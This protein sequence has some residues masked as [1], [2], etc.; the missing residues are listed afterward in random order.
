MASTPRYS[1][2]IETTAVEHAKEQMIRLRLGFLALA[3]APSLSLVCDIAKCFH[4]WPFVQAMIIF[5]QDGT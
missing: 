3:L 1:Q 2:L 5:A 4:S